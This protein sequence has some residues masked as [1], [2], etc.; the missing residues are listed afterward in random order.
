VRALIKGDFDAAFK[1][2]DLILSPTS[3]T[4]AFKIG[5]KTQDPLMMYLSDIYTISA[6][7]AGISG[8]SLPCGF[9]ESGL[10][11]GLQIMGRAFEEE[12]LLRAA[13]AFEKEMQITGARSPE[14]PG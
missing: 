4:A 7:L 6:N 14:V 11:I 12:V 2:V 8:I 3:P 5:E 9:T 1:E 13:R 10:P